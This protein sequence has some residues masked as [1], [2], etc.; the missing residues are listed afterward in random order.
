MVQARPTLVTR[1]DGECLRVDVRPVVTLAVDEVRGQELGAKPRGR[2]RGESIHML[3][4]HQR[5]GTEL[6]AGAT[7]DEEWAIASG[8]ESIVMA[9]QAGDANS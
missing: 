2:S 5:L 3:V 7:A 1:S 9:L 4:E 8:M 6:L